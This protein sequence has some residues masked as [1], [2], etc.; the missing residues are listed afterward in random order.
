MPGGVHSSCHA[1]VLVSCLAQRVNSPLQGFYWPHLS[2]TGGGPARW[3][4]VLGVSYV[5]GVNEVSMMEVCL[6]AVA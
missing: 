1:E 4:H 6:A 3:I 5:S 2:E